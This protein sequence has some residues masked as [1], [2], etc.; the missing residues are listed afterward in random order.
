MQEQWKQKP[1]AAVRYMR[2]KKHMDDPNRYLAYQPEGGTVTRKTPECKY[3]VYMFGIG[4]PEK[5]RCR[6]FIAK[7]FGKGL[8]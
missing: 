2:L 8:R 3:D 6:N 7:H 1:E 4:G 5:R